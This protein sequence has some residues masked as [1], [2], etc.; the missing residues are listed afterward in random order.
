MSL[1]FPRE[2]RS[3]RSPTPTWTRTKPITPQTDSVPRLDYIRQEFHC[4]DVLGCEDHSIF[5]F[6]VCK[7][8][9][10]IGLC[11]GGL[12]RAH[13]FVMNNCIE[14]CLRDEYRSEELYLYAFKYVTNK[15][16]ERGAVPFDDMQ[17]MDNEHRSG[18]FD[19]ADVGYR[20]VTYRCSLKR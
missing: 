14:I 16:L 15:V 2:S 10:I 4:R 1:P 17:N 20:T 18:N 11:I 3:A 12:Q 13:D 9:E 6:F 8:N 5:Q 7:N 19:S